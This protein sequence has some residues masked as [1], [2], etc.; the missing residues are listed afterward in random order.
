MSQFAVVH[1]AFVLAG[2]VL[3]ASRME[4]VN[5]DGLFKL[6]RVGSFGH[7]FVILPL[8]ASQIAH[9]RCGPRR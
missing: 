7:P 3:P 4:F 1:P 6:I 8:V 5:G 9:D 2:L